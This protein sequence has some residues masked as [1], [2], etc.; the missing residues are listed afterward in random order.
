M[1]KRLASFDKTKIYYNYNKGNLPLCLVF[2][3]GVGGNWTVW[4]KEINFLHKKGYGTLAIDLR[5]HGCSDA[6]EDIQKYKLDH[7]SHDVHQIIKREKIQKFVL[8]GHSLGGGVAI[9]YCINYPK[10]LPSSMI[11]IET[12][13]L[14]PFTKDR[15]LNLKPYLNHFL[16]F[17]SEHKL[18]QREHFFHLKDIDLSVEGINNQLNLISHLIHLTPI[19]TMVKA[20]D[21]L[22]QYVFHNKARIQDTL[23]K[24]KIPV[25]IIAGDK[26][27]VVPPKFSLVMKRLINNSELKMIKDNHHFVIIEKAEEVSQMIHNFLIQNFYDLFFI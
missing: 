16:R 5:G 22:E 1:E 20:L 27:P 13:S 4:K 9:N 11:M 15:L 8:I 23:H 25:L 19:R 26:D 24:L 18:T 7:F 12:A 2:L 21:N 10:Q 17:V 14:Y 3:H 6:P